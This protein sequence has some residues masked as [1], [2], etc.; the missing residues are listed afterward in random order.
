M[1]SK[2][3]AA[4]AWLERPG[5]AGAGGIQLQCAVRSQETA[6]QHRLGAVFVCMPFWLVPS[7][8]SEQ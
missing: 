4:I 8:G 5:L 1:N 6:R 2:A 7:A 3:A